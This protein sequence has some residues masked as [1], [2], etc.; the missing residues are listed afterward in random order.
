LKLRFK[1]KK[2]HKKKKSKVIKIKNKKF[3][4]KLKTKKRGKER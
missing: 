4:K 3:F 1:N 2:S